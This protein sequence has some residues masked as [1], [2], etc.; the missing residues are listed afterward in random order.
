MSVLKNVNHAIDPRPIFSLYN[1]FNSLTFISGMTAKIT[2]TPKV[3]S[4]RLCNN[5]VANS[6]VTP[7]TTIVTIDDS[8]LYAPLDSFTAD[9]ENEPDTGILPLML[10]VILDSPCPNNSWL[11]STGVGFL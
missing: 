11:E 2:I 5:G 8:P 7:T 6:S 3:A 4:G 9:L 10:D 1:L